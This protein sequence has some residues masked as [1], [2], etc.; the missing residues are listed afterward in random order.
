MKKIFFAC[1]LAFGLPGSVEAA[2]ALSFIST[3]TSFVGQGA[4][5]Y[6]TPADNFQ[7]SSQV[8][9]DNSLTFLIEN[10]AVSPAVDQRYWSLTLWGPLN[11]TLASGFYDH[12]GVGRWPFGNIDN[13]DLFFYGNDRFTV[14]NL[15]YFDVLEAVYDS[16][17]TVDSFAV[18]FVQFEAG[19]SS[20]RIDGKLR[21]NST[22]G[23]SVVPEPS[24][25]LLITLG[26][27]VLAIGRKGFLGRSLQSKAARLVLGVCLVTVNAEASTVSSDFIMTPDGVQLYYEY[28]Q[29]EPEREKGSVV[30]L[31]GWGMSYNEWDG[32]KERFQEDGWSTMAFD[33]RGHGA[34]IEA[35]DRQIFHEDLLPPSE[36]KKLLIDIKMMME[37]LQTDKPVWLVGS[38]IG[39]NYAL[40]YGTSNKRVHG[41]IL[42]APGYD[43][44]GILNPGVIQRYGDRPVMIAAAGNN[45]WSMRTSKDLK[46]KA[47]GPKVLYGVPGGH[48][49]DGLRDKM[50]FVPAMLEWVNEQTPIPDA[51]QTVPAAP[52][53]PAGDTGV[54][55]M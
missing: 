4:S 26:L 17:G 35:H 21:F 50:P 31:H 5:V 27:I 9:A 43:D 20:R 38:S 1:L 15:G 54:R 30:F 12:A 37:Y 41:V 2:T 28:T 24:T 14:N 49:M 33:F 42:L 44:F 19:D 32:V 46:S 13:P 48:E 45:P 29:V 51:L 16:A 6:V 7:F 8:N 53:L 34:S 23:T 25:F 22:Y 47:L 3:D 18:D 52:P 55:K 10:L 40:L 36:R 11:Q 39:A